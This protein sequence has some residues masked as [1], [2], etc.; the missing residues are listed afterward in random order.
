MTFPSFYFQTGGNYD[1]DDE[2]PRSSGWTTPDPSMVFRFDQTT[3]EIIPPVG[4]VPD[5]TPLPSAAP[6]DGAMG[7]SSSALTTVDPIHDDQVTGESEKEASDQIPEEKEDKINYED[8]T[9]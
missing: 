6:V 4:Y 2:S 5:G 9:H 7:A 1:E 8:S 3:G